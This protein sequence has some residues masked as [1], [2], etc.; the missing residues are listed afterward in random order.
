M[1]SVQEQQEAKQVT[2][3]TFVRQNNIDFIAVHSLNFFCSD[4]GSRCCNVFV[5]GFFLFFGCS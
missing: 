2:S 3:A 4:L 1:W 5:L